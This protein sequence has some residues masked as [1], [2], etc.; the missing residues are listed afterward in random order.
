LYCLHRLRIIDTMKDDQAVRV[1][2]AK[3]SPDEVIHLNNSHRKGGLYR[4]DCW[5]RPFLHFSAR[6]LRHVFEFE[7]E[8]MAR[9]I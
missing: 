4:C 9:I 8:V 5:P 1:V 7:D 2:R 3:P 6:S